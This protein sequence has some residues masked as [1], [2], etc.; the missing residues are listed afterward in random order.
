MKK[1]T[2][3]AVALRPATATAMTSTLISVCALT[4][5]LNASRTT[6]QKTGRAG[7]STDA[8]VFCAGVLRGR[9]SSR[10]PP[11]VGAAGRG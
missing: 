5:R 4:R 9:I 10:S 7:G 8:A 2:A 3:V 6:L 1:T 11:P